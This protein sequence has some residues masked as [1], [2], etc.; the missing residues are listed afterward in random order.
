MGLIFGLSSRGPCIFSVRFDLRTITLQFC[1]TKQAR[2]ELDEAKRKVL[3]RQL[4]LMVRDG[5]LILP[6]F[7]D[8]IMASSKTLKG[9]VDDIGN[10]MSNGYIGSYVWFIHSSWPAP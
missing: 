9:Y 5:G 4:A 1:A 8:Y 10:D 3:Y 7:N 2:S 6:V